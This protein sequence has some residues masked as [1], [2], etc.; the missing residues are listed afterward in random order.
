MGDQIVEQLI[1]VD[2]VKVTKEQFQEMNNNPNIRLKEIT[3]GV[4]KTLQKLQG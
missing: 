3:P 2:G 1:E 4:Y